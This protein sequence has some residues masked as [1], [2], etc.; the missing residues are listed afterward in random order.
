MAS[1]I[2]LWVC[3]NC[4]EY[5]KGNSNE[6]SEQCVQHKCQYQVLKNDNFAKIHKLLDEENT[7]PPA[8][9]M[10][11]PPPPPLDLPPP[12][13]F[14]MTTNVLS[15]KSLMDRINACKLKKAEEKEKV[16]KG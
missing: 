2:N 14:E 8:P 7:K 1:S 5:K 16:K 4:G 9:T 10:A 12:T 13:P 11:A 6:T 15:Q 3:L